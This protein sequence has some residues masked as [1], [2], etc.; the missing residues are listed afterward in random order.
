MAKQTVK[1]K[2]EEVLVEHLTQVGYPPA[3]IG[4]R[5]HDDRGWMFDLAWPALMLAVEVDGRGRHQTDK[6]RIDDCQKLNAAL[7]MGWRVLRFP[8]SS[9]T[10][11]KRRIRIVDQIARILCGVSSPEDAECVLVGE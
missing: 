5:F 1:S 3:E 9:V 6:G 2:A 8:A 4:H 11:T 10:T 7:E